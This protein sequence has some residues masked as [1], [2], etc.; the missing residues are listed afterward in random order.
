MRPLRLKIEINTREHFTVLGL[1]NQLHSVAN[2]WFAG[3][4]DVK[5]FELDEL[6]GTKLHAL[7]QRR[8]SRDLFDL[9]L[10]LSNVGPDGAFKQLDQPVER[11]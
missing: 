7:C 1:K 2:P 6:M 10:C 9:W 5:T 8:R 3:T 11:T 4:A